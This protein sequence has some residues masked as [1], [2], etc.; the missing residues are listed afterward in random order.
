MM[1]IYQCINYVPS[2]VR[3]ILEAIFTDSPKILYRIDLWPTI[4][5]AQGPNT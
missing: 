2:P 5:A 1:R 3:D 4:P